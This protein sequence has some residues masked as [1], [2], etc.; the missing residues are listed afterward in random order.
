[1]I[2]TDTMEFGTRTG[3][4]NNF[5]F[6]RYRLIISKDI[7]AKCTLNIGRVSLVNDDD[8][9]MKLASVFL[10]WE[11]VFGEAPP[12]S[13][14]G[15]S[16]S[17]PMSQ[18]SESIPAENMK[19]ECILTHITTK[20]EAQMNLYPSRSDM[21]P[22][23][24]RGLRK[25]SVLAKDYPVD[26]AKKAKDVAGDTVVASVEYKNISSTVWNVGGQHKY[27]LWTTVGK[28]VLAKDYPVD[29][30]KK[31]KDVAGDTVVATVE[32]KNISSTVWNVG[33]QHKVCI[34]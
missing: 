5:K 12:T 14:A 17:Q 15:S 32:Y 7:L 25:K 6:Y 18:D 19:N 8:K 3:I 31:A 22:R 16:E 24:G 20:G 33:G 30:A 29:R 11:F 4:T 34:S 13:L 23:L 21:L 9:D 26:R 27:R 1:C 10:R 2:L 28:S